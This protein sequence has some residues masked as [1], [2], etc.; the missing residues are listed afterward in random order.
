MAI[1]KNI[2]Y[3]PTQT[4]AQSPLSVSLNTLNTNIKKED[5]Q[6]NTGDSMKLYAQDM[7]RSLLIGGLMVLLL[8][9]LFIANLQYK[10][11]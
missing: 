11:L 4:R 7:K 8:I 1:R 5:A 3:S 9:G 6:S 2:E 10:F